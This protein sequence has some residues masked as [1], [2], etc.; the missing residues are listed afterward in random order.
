MK[1]SIFRL[2]EEIS[3]YD[4]QKLPQKL[5][6]INVQIKVIDTEISEYVSFKN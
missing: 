1:Y 6:E 2:Y 4:K 3:N 5:L